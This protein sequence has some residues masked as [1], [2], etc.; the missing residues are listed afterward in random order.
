MRSPLPC[1]RLSSRCATPPQPFNETA[2]Y[3]DHAMSPW[4]PLLAL[5]AASLVCAYLRVGLRAWT[6]AGFAAIF[7]AGWLSGA[8]P[9]AI[10]L[11]AIVFAAVSVP[12]NI[13]D[14]RRQKLT[15]PLLKVYEKITPQLSD[16][17]RV[18]L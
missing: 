6:I 4:Y 7:V 5:L 15:A 10:A 14:F 16:T 17:E 8:G 1:A 18:A 11:T 9:L 13:P 12:L 3:E 2:F